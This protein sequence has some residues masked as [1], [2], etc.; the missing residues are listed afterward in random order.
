MNSEDSLLE[1][2]FDANRELSSA[3]MP[4]REWSSNAKGLQDPID[5]DQ[6]GAQTVSVNLLGLQWNVEEDTLELHPVQ[7]IS[8]SELPQTKRTFLSDVSKVFDPLGFCTPVTVRG[9]ILLQ[10]AWKLT[11][12]WD[13][14]LP[15]DI[16]DIWTT[17]AE[18][19]VN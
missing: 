18:I 4:L 16:T 2:Y 14:P 15:S 8:S 9:K 6:K 13:E 10:K 7:F 11:I 3:N 5:Q 17:L 19:C 1:Y 12:T